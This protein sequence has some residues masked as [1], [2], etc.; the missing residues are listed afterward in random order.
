MLARAASPPAPPRHRPAR[1]LPRRSPRRPL[2]CGECRRHR[3]SRRPPA[4]CAL[5][6][7]PP[8]A[9]APRKCL[10]SVNEV[11]TKCLGSTGGR[12]DGRRRCCACGSRAAPLRLP[13]DAQS[14][15][16]PTSRGGTIL[17]SRKWPSPAV[18]TH[19]HR[20]ADPPLLAEPGRFPRPSRRPAR[21]AGGSRKA[22]P[23]RRLDP[24]PHPPDRRPTSAPSGGPTRRKTPRRTAARRAR[25]PDGRKCLASRAAE[26][27]R[28]ADGSRCSPPSPL[29]RCRSP[30]PAG[31]GLRPPQPARGRA[32]G[33]AKAARRRRARRVHGQR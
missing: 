22:Q 25:L 18:Q 17:S 21:R 6:A 19:T 2:T 10:G 4:W 24:P 9:A 14:H 1:L 33:A 30:R 3:R 20:S 7:P 15:S 5:R 29:R 23:R 11:S 27:K 32:G 8:T 12:P 31:R 16:S 26:T 28:H 13:S